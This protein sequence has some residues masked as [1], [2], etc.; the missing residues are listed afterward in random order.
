MVGQVLDN[1]VSVEDVVGDTTCHFIEDNGLLVNDPGWIPVASALN[2][3]LWVPVLVP[4][5]SCM[6][7]SLYHMHH[8]MQPQTC[9]H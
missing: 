8:Q 1:L 5:I 9:K 2:A 7:L 6:C 3:D 4:T